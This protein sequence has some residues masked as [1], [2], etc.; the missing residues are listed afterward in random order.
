M[1]QNIK[2]MLS[3]NLCLQWRAGKKTIS[4]FKSEWKQERVVRNVEL[5]S[6]LRAECWSTKPFITRFHFHTLLWLMATA[7][8]VPDHPPPASGHSS[9]HLD[10]HFVFGYD[11][12]S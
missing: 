7:L 3:F 9:G 1:F 12:A 11:G 5:F 2:V 10:I 4:N 8:G 6:L